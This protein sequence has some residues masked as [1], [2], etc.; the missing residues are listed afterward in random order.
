M[1]SATAAHKP[2]LRTLHSD[3]TLT[4]SSPPFLSGLSAAD[5]SRA[6]RACVGA[7]F[8]AADVTST[9]VNAHG[10][11]TMRVVLAG[12]RALQ[13]YLLAEVREAALPT[14]DIDLH[15]HAPNEETFDMFC[16]FVE[17]QCRRALNLC[18]ICADDH[19]VCFK[20]KRQMKKDHIFFDVVHFSVDIGRINAV[21]AIDAILV[22]PGVYSSMYAE[23]LHGNKDSCTAEPSTTAAVP[24]D[25]DQMISRQ[26][27]AYVYNQWKESSVYVM[28]VV[29][30]GYGHECTQD[31]AWRCHVQPV[32]ELACGLWKTV[33][34]ASCYRRSKDEC[35]RR[36]MLYLSRAGIVSKTPIAVP[37]P[38][39]ACPGPAGVA[40]DKCA[41]PVKS[42]APLC[43]DDGYMWSRPS[44][45]S[46]IVQHG[47]C[48]R[49]H[50]CSSVAAFVA[51]VEHKLAQMETICTQKINRAHDAAA[52]AMRLAAT[53]V[54]SLK[55]E[56]AA[57]KHTKQMHAKLVTVQQQLDDKLRELKSVKHQ[58]AL[59]V[60]QIKSALN[61]SQQEQ[62]R[63][64]DDLKR[65]NE[66]AR[67]QERE[68]R[69]VRDKLRQARRE[70]AL[71]RVEMDDLR[72]SQQHKADLPTTMTAAAAAGVKIESG[73]ATAQDT[74]CSRCVRRRNC[75][76]HF[77]RIARVCFKAHDE[78]IRQ[79][80]SHIEDKALTV[81][82]CTEAFARMRHVVAA[83]A[84][85]VRETKELVLEHI[86]SA[87]KIKPFESEFLVEEYRKVAQSMR[88]SGCAIVHEGSERAY[89]R[90]GTTNWVQYAQATAHY[91]LTMSRFNGDVGD[92]DNWL[93]DISAIT[94]PEMGSEDVSEKSGWVWFRLNDKKRT[95]EPVVL[96]KSHRPAPAL[97][98]KHSVETV[99]SFMCIPHINHALAQS[100][101]LQRIKEFVQESMTTC[102]KIMTGVLKETQMTADELETSRLGRLTN[103]SLSV[104]TWE[105]WGPSFLRTYMTHDESDPALKLARDTSKIKEECE[106]NT[107]CVKSEEDVAYEIF[108]ML[109]LP[110]VLTRRERSLAENKD[111]AVKEYQ[112]IHAQKIMPRWA[113]GDTFCSSL[114]K[115][116]YSQEGKFIIGDD[117][118]DGAY[119][120]INP[121]GVT[122]VAQA[123]VPSDT[124]SGTGSDPS[125]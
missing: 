57:H 30:P 54:L 86:Q 6:T 2:H 53:C 15:V 45:W 88:H 12:A 43:R 106:H 66:H 62:R 116:V 32:D 4:P 69:D 51:H 7:A 110:H 42:L 50:I 97:L 64:S 47:S 35:R 92:W 90:F 14:D 118:D 71:C 34:D 117:A 96:P 31:K 103:P 112:Q 36:L 82:R 87:T 73:D 102:D 48:I 105:E 24:S 123:Y 111:K 21:R 79:T 125:E 55:E 60:R 22:S 109:V 108:K 93:C 23:I 5:R 119:I 81:T 115:I 11:G 78:M 38:Y 101:H 26:H 84:Q 13:C 40:M 8:L 80:N 28:G 121:A 77:R 10:G 75:V 91:V 41:Q 49:S 27:K 68:Q 114:L 1:S 113:S 52:K 65:A 124:F 61:V 74:S 56:R 120:H 20:R 94:K 100:H 44:E 95:M 70:L 83:V 17:D 67:T 98:F 29:G 9:R 3:S 18:G 104:A 63:Y 33:N 39:V 122:D 76:H 107:M 16:S 89:A 46:S 85:S 59:T 19:L 99:C 58:N 37:V 25:C 72:A